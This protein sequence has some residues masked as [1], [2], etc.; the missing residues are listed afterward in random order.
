M[1][2][3]YQFFLALLGVVVFSTTNAQDYSSLIEQHL[4]TNRASMGLTQEDVS[5]V[6]VIDQVFTQ[7]NRTTSV[8]AV[9]RHNG[10]EIYNAIANFAIK[11]NQVVYF[12]NSLS[13]NIVS[14]VNTVSPS[15]TAVQAA[16]AAANALGLGS[17]TFSI[18]NAISNQQFVL[19]TGGVSQEN[20]NIKLVFTEFEDALRLAWDLDILTLD[21]NNWFSVRVDATNG[22]ILNQGDWIVSCNFGD[23]EHL[24]AQDHV[25]AHQTGFGFRNEATPALVGAGETYNVYPLP[26]ESPNHGDRAIVTEPQ[27]LVASPFGWHDTDGADGADFTITRG[28]NVWAQEDTNGNNGVGTSPD[29]GSELTFD[30]PFDNEID[31][32]NFIPAATTNLFYW[33]NVIHDIFYHYGFDEASGNFQENNYGN[34]GSSSDSVDADSQDGSGT[35]NAN[36]GTPPDG[37]NPRMQMFLW[38]SRPPTPNVATIASGDLAGDYDITNAVFGPGWPAGGLV[39]GSLV[40]ALDNDT[41]GDENDACDPLTNAADF[42]GSIAVIRRGTCPFVQKVETAEAAGAI[43]VIIVNNVADAP[44]DLGGDGPGVGIPSGMVSQADGEAII[45]ALE[46][47]GDISISILGGDQARLDSDF[48]NLV[49]GHEYGH[50]I[51][52]RLTGGRFNSGCLQDAE[53]GGMGEGWS[54]YIGLM[55]TMDEDDT[56]EEGRGVGTYVINEGTGGLGIRPRRYSTNFA[57]NDLT[58]DDVSDA[59]NISQ[60]HGIG[61]VWATMLWDMTWALIDEYGF[62][63]DL[64]NGTGGNNLALQ[65]VV[66]GMKLQPCNPGFITA[67]D[68]I[69]AAVDI[70]EQ[71]TDEERDFVRCTVWGAFANRGAGFSASQGSSAS[72][73]DQVEAF[74]MPPNDILNCDEVLSVD[75]ASLESAFSVYPNPSNGQMTISVNGTFGE[76]QITIVDINGRVVYTQDALLEGNITVDAAALRTGIYIMSI[77]T[78]TNIVTNKLVIE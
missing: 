64:Y 6:V 38:T 46:N 24:S 23:H 53:G 72:R 45:T 68:G 75:D 3:I 22:T 1:R 41:T 10:I 49:I 59:T 61:T 36:F 21:N 67:R 11:D 60:P 70:N 58:F 78:A 33:N 26:I 13:S 62:D 71:I 73:F 32:A 66:D 12:S 7:H 74:D 5:D 43:A 37:Q 54:D 9:Q 42:G 4:N 35:N 29:G 77:T 2:K 18:E 27:D 48:D 30:F 50:G 31:A 55:L 16:Q 44:I 8:Y 51:S 40:L 28:N 15:L 52:T 57:L 14:R 47:G 69:L 65:L 19:N 39:E 17:A 25:D 76:G 56:A 34:G 63:S 20:V